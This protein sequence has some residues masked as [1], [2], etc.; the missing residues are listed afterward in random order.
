MKLAITGVHCPS[1][2]EWYA[3]AVQE[4]S[5]TQGLL[6]FNWSED[7]AKWI[8]LI[9]L[10]SVHSFALITSVKGMTDTTQFPITGYMAGGTTSVDTSQACT[11]NFGS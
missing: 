4:S 9:N 8:D 10:G 11:L 1:N 2:Y 3:M 6:Y 7:Q 5:V